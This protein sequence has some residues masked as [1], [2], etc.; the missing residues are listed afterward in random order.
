MCVCVCVCVCVFTCLCCIRICTHDMYMLYVTQGWEDVT[1]LK[2][3]MVTQ[4][5]KVDQLKTE[6]ADLDKA[7][8]SLKVWATRGQVFSA[9]AP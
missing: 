3:E 1:Q 6:L 4:Q 9:M 7:E 8:N 5:K 2:D